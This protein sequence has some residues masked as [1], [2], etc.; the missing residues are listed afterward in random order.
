MRKNVKLCQSSVSAKDGI[1]ELGGGGGAYALHPI[2]KLYP[3]GGQRHSTNVGAVW[4][5]E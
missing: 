5:I 2:A 4:N 1:L 3:Q